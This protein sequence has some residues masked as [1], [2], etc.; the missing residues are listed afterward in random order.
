MVSTTEGFTYNS[1]FSH[2]PYVTTKNTSAKKSMDQISKVLDIKQKIAVH[3]LGAD[4]SKC[5]AIRAC[6]MLGSSIP[7][8]LGNTKINE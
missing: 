2:V 4:K 1:K 3:R 5:K 8:R 6:S 7:N